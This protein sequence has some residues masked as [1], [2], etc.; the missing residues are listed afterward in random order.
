[1]ATCEETSTEYLCKTKSFPH[2]LQETTAEVFCMCGYRAHVVTQAQWLHS[3]YPNTDTKC[4][5]I[6]L[7]QDFRTFDT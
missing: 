5:V 7:A 6:T 2:D 4:N 1:M 3:Y